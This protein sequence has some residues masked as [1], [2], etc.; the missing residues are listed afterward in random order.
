[1]NSQ[2][3]VSTA[4]IHELIFADDCT[5]NATTGEDM[6]SSMYLFAVACDNFGLCINT[7]KTTVIHKPPPDI[8]YSAARVNVN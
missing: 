4:N 2:S 7:E 6:Q 5:L 1:M 3:R 8:I